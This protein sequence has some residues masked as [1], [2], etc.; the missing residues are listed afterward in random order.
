M[1]C[2]SKSKVAVFT[3]DIAILAGDASVDFVYNDSGLIAYCRSKICNQSFARDREL[4]KRYGHIISCYAVHPG[5]VDSNLVQPM[6]GIMGN[7][8]KAIRSVSMID[9]RL[10][11]Q[12]SLFC[13]LT[14]NIPPGSYFHICEYHPTANNDSWSEKLWNARKS[15][16]K[17]A[18][19]IMMINKFN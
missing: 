7:I 11:A 18:L 4:H 14:D 6:E 3:G 13:C 5:V 2:H 10:G 1:L 8:E 9:C 17:K 12:S 16:L 15:E 19:N